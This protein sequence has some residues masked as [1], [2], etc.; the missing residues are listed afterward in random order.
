VVYIGRKNCLNLNI[1]TYLLAYI[2]AEEGL[3][4]NKLGCRRS[5]KPLLLRSGG[6]PYV[7]CIIKG[8]RVVVCFSANNCK[9]GFDGSH[10][11]MVNKRVRIMRRF[12]VVYWK[13]WYAGNCSKEDELYL[14]KKI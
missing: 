10:N 3:G 12:K 5:W 9:F 13:V 7:S 6:H 2:R 8:C 11:F 1:I 4:F 14:C